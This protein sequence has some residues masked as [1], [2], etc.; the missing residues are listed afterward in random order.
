MYIVERIKYNYQVSFNYWFRFD[1]NVPWWPE[2]W[3]GL[4]GEGVMVADEERLR[5][6][7][8]GSLDRLLHRRYPIHAGNVANFV[9]Y[10][11]Y[12]YMIYICI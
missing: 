11:V 12:T 2:D 3:V 1:W 8:V 4:P 9:L 7:Q 6:G 10:N 5:D